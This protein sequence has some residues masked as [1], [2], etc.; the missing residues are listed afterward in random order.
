VINSLHREGSARSRLPDA[1]SATAG[2]PRRGL[3]GPI[4]SAP[5]TY[6]V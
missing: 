6:W 2:K 5:A 3:A 1:V 4:C